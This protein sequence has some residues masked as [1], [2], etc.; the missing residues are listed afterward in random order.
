MWSPTSS[1]LICG[2]RDAILV[3]TPA[4]TA[5]AIAL[6]DRV[7]KSEKDLTTIYTTHGHGDHFF[8]NGIL[9][10]VFAVPRRSLPPK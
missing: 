8:G 9:Q 10:S 5:Q 1:I 6:A 7:E 2:K 4:T 3:D